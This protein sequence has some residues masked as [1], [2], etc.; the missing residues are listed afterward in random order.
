MKKDYLSKLRS[1]ENISLRQQI[2]MIVTLSMPAIMAQ[3]SSIIMQY[4]DTSMVGR[5]GSAESASIGLIASSTWLMN[6]LLTAAVTGFTVQVAQKIGA[7]KE[8]DAR[9]IMKHGFVFS[10]LIAAILA[11][12][13]AAVS[14]HLPIFLGGGED[15]R[16]DAAQYFLIFALSLPAVQV[17]SL[18]GGMLQ[19]SGNMRLPGLLNVLMCFLDVI[20]NFL[21]IFPSREVF[22]IMI[23]GAGLGVAGASLG[24]AMSQVVTAIIMTV[25]LLLKSPSLHLR[26]GEK[27]RFNSTYIR[28]GTKVALPVALEQAVMCS[29][30]IMATKIVSPLGNVAIAANSFAVTAESLCYM[31]GYGIGAASTTLIGQSIGAGR[32]TLTRRLGWLCTLFGM[33]VMTLSG[34]FMF[35]AAPYMIGFLTPDV[36]VV[37]LGTKILRIEAFA[38]PMYAASIAASGVFRGAGDTLASSL[39]NFLSMW[40]VRLPLSAFLASRMG[41]VGVWVAMCIELCVRGILFLIRLSGHR[42]EKDAL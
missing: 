31:P 21:F 28:T 11:A 41:L 12:V 22:G 15:I 27:T 4:I 19:A 1:G 13:G 14:W 35:F 42:W 38:E 10:V 29:A 20:F 9:D 33:G 34:V 6:G 18:S 24:T 7:G 3:I 8:R 39:M 32:K 2:V 17:C 37:A 16:R 25:C 36:E 5:L 30:Y 26:R 23:P 40:L